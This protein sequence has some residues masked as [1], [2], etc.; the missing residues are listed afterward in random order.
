MILSKAIGGYFRIETKSGISYHENGMALNSG[1]NCLKYIL[2]EREYS[3][4]YL[5]FYT[6][7]SILEPLKELNIDYEF[8]SID[9][10]M[11]LIKVPKII[12]GSALLYINYFG[13]KSDYIK[14]LAGSV[15]NLIVDAVQAFFMKA[16]PGIDTFY[17]PR[18]FF[19][20]P[21]GGYV[22]SEKILSKNLPEDF[23]VDRFSHLLLRADQGAEDGYEDFVHNEKSFS[24]EPIRKMSKLTKLLMDSIDYEFCLKKRNENFRYLHEHLKEENEIKWIE[25]ASLNGP[26]VYPFL[27]NK[28]G[29]RE[30]LIKNRVYIATYWPNLFDLTEKNSFEFQLYENLL[31]L[32]IDQR[33]GKEE[34]EFIIEK[35]LEK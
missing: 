15:H 21:D 25:P 20:V 29:L 9:K 17:S 16:I 2:E 22:Y 5:P 23:S 3:H 27:S 24:W 31:P 6:C 4:I 33:Y 1:R 26:M 10:S 8:Y 30:K 11:E 14:R 32:P 19:G 28:N 13:L 18:K 35:V 7:D 34:M 12:K